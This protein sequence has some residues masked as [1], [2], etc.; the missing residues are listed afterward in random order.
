MTNEKL[1]EIRSRGEITAQEIEEIQDCK[2]GLTMYDLFGMCPSKDLVIPKEVEDAE[3]KY[4]LGVLN[5]SRCPFKGREKY[6]I[7]HVKSIKLSFFW[8]GREASGKRT[9]EFCVEDHKGHQFL[10]FRDRY[11]RCGINFCRG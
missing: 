6:I 5:D 3:M 4:L 9:P 7:R 1:L 2:D 8:N 10:Y 11:S